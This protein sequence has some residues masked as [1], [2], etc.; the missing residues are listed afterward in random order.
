MVQYTFRLDAAFTA[1]SDPTRRAILERLAGKDATTTDLAEAHGMTLTGML[2]HLRVL[3]KAGLVVT[4]KVGRVR[5]CRLGPSRLKNEA[6]WIE[7]H[8]QMVEARLDRLGRFLERTK[9]AQS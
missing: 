5:Y 3:E 6:F 2:K 1:I 9:G 8:R 4:Q 7:K